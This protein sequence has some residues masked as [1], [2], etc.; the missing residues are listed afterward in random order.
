MDYSKNKFLSHFVALLPYIFFL[1]MG[2]ALNRSHGFL[3]FNHLCFITISL[4]LYCIFYLKQPRKINLNYS[5]ILSLIWLIFSIFLVLSPGLIYPQNI[6][7]LLVLK[8][9]LLII[10]AFA[11]L[12]NYS[13]FIRPIKFVINNFSIIFF[14]SIFLYIITYILVLFITKHPTIDVFT[15]TSIGADNLLN[16]LNPYTQNYPD[17]LEGRY[18]Y[19]AGYVYWPVILYV[20]T[21]T[22]FI[23]HDVRAAYIICALIT[24]FL[25]EKIGKQFNVAPTKRQLIILCW[26]SFPV[27]LF[28][29]E[30]SWTEYL[31]IVETI[32]IIFFLINKKIFISGIIL[33][34]MAAT[35]QYNIF[36]ILFLLI[37]IYKIYSLKQTITIIA[38]ALTTFILLISP[39]F[40]LDYKTFLNRTIFDML[41]YNLR[42]D[43]LSW[44][45]YVNHFYGIVPTGIFY[46]TIYSLCLLLFVTRCLRQKQMSLFHLCS[47]IFCVYLVVFL[48]GKQAFCNYYYLSAFYLLLIILFQ[49]SDS[50]KTN[51]TCCQ[52]IV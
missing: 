46:A 40:I 17:I 15:V 22:K 30:Q 33:G 23:F 32:T 42:V 47:T 36:L 38:T 28:V 29:L 45:A 37:Y 20:L 11:A 39:F 44:P 49:N 27:T 12:T 52:E 41:A 43:A 2:H 3:K 19:V 51:P 50:K 16:G 1:I 6:P 26:Q 31:I 9:I 48:F 7:Q 34:I 21:I 13:Y 5:K 8:I 4:I 35:K 14:V 10:C 18:G 25:L 24:I